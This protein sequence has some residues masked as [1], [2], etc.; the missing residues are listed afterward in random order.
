MVTL[1]LAKKIV[2]GVEPDCFKILGVSGQD[3]SG[4]FED[5]L[6]FVSEGQRNGWANIIFFENLPGGLPHRQPWI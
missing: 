5:T 2:L 6:L 1:P 3:R 4:D